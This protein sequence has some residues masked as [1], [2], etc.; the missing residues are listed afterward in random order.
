[1]K[2][3]V[4]PIDTKLSASK[5]R[6]IVDEFGRLSVHVDDLKKKKDRYDQL[7]TQIANWHESD[8]AEATFTEEGNQWTVELSARSLEREITSI[9]KLTKYLGLS[10]FLELCKF[11]LGDIDKHVPVEDRAEF[12]SCER[13]G[14]RTLKAIAKDIDLKAA[15]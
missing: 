13:T 3:Q 5:R 1:M 8:D 11:S 7:R 10:R 12:V 2:A 4:I 6:E 15:A 14:S 9:P